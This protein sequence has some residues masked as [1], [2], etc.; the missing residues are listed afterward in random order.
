MKKIGLLALA[1]VLALGT[2]GVAY[3]AWTDTITID[4]TVNTGSVDLEIIELSSTFVYKVPDEVAGQ[5]DNV[6]DEMVVV[7][8]RVNMRPLVGPTWSVINVPQIPP[9]GILVS[10]ATATSPSDDHITVTFDNAFPCP[11]LTADFIVHYVGS[12]PVKVDAEIT[13]FTGEAGDLAL[14][15]TAATVKF[16]EWDEATGTIGQEIVDGPVQL[17]YCDYVYCVMTLLIPQED[18]Y[19]NLNGGFTAEIFAVQW[20]EYPY[21]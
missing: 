21:P 8:Q 18:A 20:N 1:M 14:L 15:E 19:M 3:A 16:F 10:S 2:F 13:D 9:N 17:H 4:G 7:H 12:I 11:T 5:Y 6:A